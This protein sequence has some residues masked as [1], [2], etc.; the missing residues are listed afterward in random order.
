MGRHGTGM[1]DFRTSTRWFAILL[2]LWG[3]GAWGETRFVAADSPSPEPP[4]SS[5][6]TAARTIQEAIDI[7]EYGD[8][9]LVT[10]GVYNTGGATVLS[11][12][13]N[14][15]VLTKAVTVLSVNGPR[16]TIIQGSGPPGDQAVR[17]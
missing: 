6:A 11:I 14:R 10:N 12:L 9:V 2:C 3:G 1:R 13:T 4:Y 5:W 17:C 8:T 7:A 16:V 15:V